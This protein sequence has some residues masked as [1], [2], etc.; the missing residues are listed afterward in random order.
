[1]D[2]PRLN[3]AVAIGQPKVAGCIVVALLDNGKVAITESHFD[4][5]MTNAVLAKAAQ[6]HTAS[7][8]FTAQMQVPAP[9]GVT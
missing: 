7:L 3:G 5:L 4:A 8:T 1:M 6:L 2:V 9:P